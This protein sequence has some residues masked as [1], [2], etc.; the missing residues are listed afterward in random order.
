MIS[1]R[2][3]TTESRTRFRLTDIPVELRAFGGSD[4]GKLEPSELW[5]KYDDA[6]GME[7]VVHANLLIN[8]P[9]VL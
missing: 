2:E 4:D 5:K 3:A 7:V 1:A 6:N 9:Y 8:P